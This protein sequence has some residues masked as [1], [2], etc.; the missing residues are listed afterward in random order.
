MKTLKYELVVSFDEMKTI[1]TTLKEAPEVE[2]EVLALK[3]ATQTMM[4]GVRV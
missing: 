3:L 2:A 1:I 4:D